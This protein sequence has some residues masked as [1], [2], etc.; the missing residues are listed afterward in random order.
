MAITLRPETERRIAE[1]MRVGRYASADDV[2]EAGL[3]LL[4]QLAPASDEDLERIRAG[5]TEGLE[6]ARRG[7]LIDGDAAL[8]ER[9]R[10]RAARQRQSD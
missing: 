2:I 3:A 5:I 8:A 4:E 10:Q 6:Q 9:R 7:E 1:Q